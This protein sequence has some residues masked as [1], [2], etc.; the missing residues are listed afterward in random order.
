[1]ERIM[2]KLQYLI[3]KFR[4]HDKRAQEQN[5]R[6][7][8]QFMENSPGQPLPEHFMDDFSLPMALASICSE[9]LAIKNRNEQNGI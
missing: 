2:Y 8:K 7:I 6:L 1:M 3:D 4:D 5:K 9:L